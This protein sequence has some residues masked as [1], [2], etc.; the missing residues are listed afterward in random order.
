M[1]Q[2]ISILSVGVYADNNGLMQR[3]YNQLDSWS[4]SSLPNSCF[5]KKFKHYNFVWY[6]LFPKHFHQLKKFLGGAQ[7]SRNSHTPHSVCIKV[8]GRVLCSRSEIKYHKLL[9]KISYY[10][11]ECSP[12]SIN[13]SY[14]ICISFPFST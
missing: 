9:S 4:L 6:P 11:L 10:C 1:L 5:Q 8:G 14:L 13:R 7:R 3:L 2:Y 12:M